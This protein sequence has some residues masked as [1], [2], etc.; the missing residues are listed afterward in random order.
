MSQVD[1]VSEIKKVVKGEVRT[2]DD[3]RKDVSGDFGRMIF[4]KPRV[5]VR[6]ASTDDVSQTLKLANRLG[7]QVSTRS[8]AHTQTG[9][10]LVDDGILIDM[11]S[12]NKILS[13]DTNAKLATCQ[14]G[15]VWRD[16]VEHLKPQ[17]LSP[18]VLTNN[19]GVTI[20]GTHSVAGL[21]IASF[22]FGA[23]VD[24]TIE[25][26]VVTGTGEIVV[27][28]A[29]KNAEVFRSFR[30]ALG[31]FGVITRATLKLRE[32]LPMTRTYFYLYDDLATFMDDSRR[33]MDEERF[34]YIESW[35]SACPQGIRLVDG[36]KQAFAQ[37]F[38]PLHATIEF[39]PAK[40]PDDAKMKAGLRFYK[41]VHTMDQPIHDFFNRLEPLFV[42]WKRIGYWA[43]MHPWMETILPWD[44]AKPYID[45]VMVNFPPQALGGGHI[46]LWP[47]K[48]T[49]SNTPMFQVPPGQKHVIGFGILPGIP[50]QFIEE[51]KPKLNLASDLSM[52]MGAK[53]Y[54]SGFIEFDHERW[55][56]HYG[57][58]WPQVVAWK[59]EFD[60]KRLLNSG[61]VVWE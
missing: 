35:C 61:F 40:P 37:W 36:V 59:K 41:H 43:N 58:L 18:P 32:H 25:M 8:E 15:V 19:L 6:P 31:Q 30:S 7:I 42:I 11:R 26:E 46:L 1:F 60:P 54:L 3:I 27:C 20:G 49:T 21:G 56:T 16:L 53:R 52:A 4:K 13:V 12:L 55:K 38:Y 44:A 9:Q 5:V 14:A 23:Q 33:L 48:G 51:A 22:R 29:D 57:D 34:G 28:S 17:R 2:D 10:A 50:P 45:Q 47:S 39:D 24:N